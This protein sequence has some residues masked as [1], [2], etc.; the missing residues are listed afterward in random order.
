MATFLGGIGSI[1]KSKKIKL[2][3][4]V[5]QNFKFI[6]G[7]STTS[8][9]W[10]KNEIIE[11]IEKAI[12][13]YLFDFDFYYNYTNNKKEYSNLY[14]KTIQEPML[15]NINKTLKDWFSYENKVLSIKNSID[16]RKFIDNWF[17]KTSIPEELKKEYIKYRK[18]YSGVI[19]K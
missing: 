14:I 4:L 17:M 15:K 16:K 1:S 6:I 3:D 8:G 9:K 18:D 11:E 5:G 13:Y 7:S 12:K 19:L 2:D 10:S